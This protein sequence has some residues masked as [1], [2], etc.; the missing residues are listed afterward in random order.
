MDLPES[1]FPKTSYSDNVE[2]LV[3]N[4]LR[5]IN[6]LAELVGMGWIG[7]ISMN[8]VGYV[9]CFLATKCSLTVDSS[10]VFRALPS[11]LGHAEVASYWCL[12]PIE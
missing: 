9:R 12:R 5:L 10:E 8:V 1:L 3:T 2:R 11:I 7:W 4:E 6:F